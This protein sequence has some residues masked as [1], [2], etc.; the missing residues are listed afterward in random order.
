MDQAVTTDRTSRPIRRNRRS[1]GTTTAEP[2]FH[3]VLRRVFAN[4]R[5]PGTKCSAE[6]FAYL[7]RITQGLDAVTVRF[8]VGNGMLRPVHSGAAQYKLTKKGAAAIS[9]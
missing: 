4:E 8:C 5:S 1:A 9:E 2:F 6:D 7:A 3:E